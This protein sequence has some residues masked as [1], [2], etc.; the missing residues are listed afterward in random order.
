MLCYTIGYHLPD[1]ADTV[2]LSEARE[3]SLPPSPA[4]FQNTYLWIV[5]RSTVMA[6]TVQGLSA[7]GAS[8]LLG[9]SLGAPE[10]H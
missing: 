9:M 1:T 5:T 8:N 2:R 10:K 6:L 3:K 4:L 7:G